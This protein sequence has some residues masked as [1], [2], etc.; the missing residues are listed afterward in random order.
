M[1]P[2]CA[3][4]C[5]GVII[6]GYGRD[7]AG[8][9]G[10]LRE[11]KYKVTSETDKS[12]QSVL[13]DVGKI[14]YGDSGGPRT[15]TRDRARFT[16]AGITS[17]TMSVDCLRGGTHVKLVG[18]NSQRLGYLEQR[19]AC[20]NPVVGLDIDERAPRGHRCRVV[21]GLEG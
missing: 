17:T 18:T 5:Y 8:Q 19:K 10:T 4:D 9:G 11:A 7:E 16:L 12:L 2:R 3:A 21:A 14:C 15:A 20:D 6:Q 13:T 1:T